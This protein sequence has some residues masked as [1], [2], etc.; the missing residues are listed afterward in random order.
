MI[1]L[2]LSPWDLALLVV[3]TIMG[4][5]LAYI[6]DP[7]WKA[8][9]VGLPFPFTIA[10]LSL[11]QQIGPSHVLGMVVLLLFTNL[12]RW[13][14]Y[15][16]KTPIVPAI[17]LSVG[18]YIAA[19]SILNRFVPRSALVF[20]IVFG[21]TLFGGVLLLVLLP[22]RVEPA[23]R[24]PLPVPVK[25]AAI[26]GVVAL[27]VVLKQ[28]LGGFMTMFPMVGT[29]A[30]YES[31]HSLWTISRQIPILI[32]TAGPMMAVMWV[33]QHCL[34]ASIPVSLAAGWVAF[35]AVMTPVTIVQ[36]RQADALSA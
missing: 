6:T 35:L 17:A 16:A 8:F 15:G 22:H 21:L 19:G 33:A 9:L 1:S 32:A 30:A 12:V 13:L 36:M 18:I 28:V 23:H 31:R 7:R 5:L 24:S 2:S 11:S 3:V 25:V 10:N 34:H 4:T 20:W 14:H 27:I 29:I 26:A